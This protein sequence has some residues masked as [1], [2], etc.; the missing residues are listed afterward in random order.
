MR[1]A[2]NHSGCT[3]DAGRPAAGLERACSSLQ[4]MRTAMRRA[5]LATSLCL[6]TMSFAV[7]SLGRSEGPAPPAAQADEEAMVGTRLPG[8]VD[9]RP[10]PAPYTD[11]YGPMG[12]YSLAVV[13]GQNLLVV[14]S[15]R[16]VLA[17]LP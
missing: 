11:G 16:R 13:E 2:V 12:D 5:V 10:L 6:A 1:S 15:T 9:L 17:T 14:S 7:A 4:P 8:Q 3:S